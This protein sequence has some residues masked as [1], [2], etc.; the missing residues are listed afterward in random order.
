[1][2][3]SRFFKFA[4][5]KTNGHKRVLQV[6]L[7]AM[8]I[9]LV[10]AGSDA[11]SQKE[12][13]TLDDA[14]I[15]FE[16]NATDG[17]LGIQIFLDGEPWNSI[18]IVSPDGKLFFEVKGKGNLRN[19]GLAELFSESNEP[20]FDDV[21]LSDIL[22]LFPPGEYQFSGKTVEREKLEG[23]AILTHNIPDGPII[24]SPEEDEVLNPDAPVVIDWDPVTTSYPGTNG[25]IN[26]VGYRVIVER[27]QPEPLLVFS[28]ELPDS[29]TQVTVSPEFIE[30]DAEYKF[31]VL[32]IETSGNQTISERSFSTEE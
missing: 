32:A 30:P 24:V 1:M 15:I 12:V 23:T 6:F 3:A 14:E 20:S 16:L 7:M 5:N 26:I 19:F 28:V 25:V 29:A 9:I 31:E 21:P 2:K 4:V 13:I 10:F 22:E 17:D 8:I 11:W 27:E 18:R